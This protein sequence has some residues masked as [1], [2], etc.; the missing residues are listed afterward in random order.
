MPLS[1]V[2]R[3]LDGSH[4]G[5]LGASRTGEE[6]RFDHVG[7]PQLEVQRLE[8]DAAAA[9]LDAR[10]PELG[11]NVRERILVEAPRWTAGSFDTSPRSG[12]RT[13][14]GP[15]KLIPASN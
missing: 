1:F 8:D 11:A 9:L 15:E 2:A 4:V 13:W 12:R 6:D 3:R 10:F 5:L 14:F 7:L